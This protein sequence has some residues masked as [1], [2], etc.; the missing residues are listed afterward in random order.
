MK[1]TF[2]SPLP[3]R[4]ISN[5]YVLLGLTIIYIAF[6]AGCAT[7]GRDFPD[8]KVKEIKIGTTTESEIRTMFGPPW[9]VGIDDGQKTWTYGRYHY[10]LLGN[11]D[12]KD[13]VVRFD[14]HNVVASYSFNTTNP[15]E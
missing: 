2:A 3:G 1:K 12:A 10:R 4:R 14:K 7:V 13:L 8:S 11:R 9:R 6:S 15:Q 5:I